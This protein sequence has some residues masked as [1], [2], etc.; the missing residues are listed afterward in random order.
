MI[1]FSEKMTKLLCEYKNLLKKHLPHEQRIIK[2]S[3]LGLKR[4]KMRFNSD[5][6][7]YQKTLSV[8]NDIGKWIESN[9]QSS[10]YSGIEEFHH[11]LKKEIQ[12]YRVEGDKIVHATQTASK[13]MVTAFQFAAFPDNQLTTHIS[14][15]LEEYSVIIVKYGTDEQKNIFANAL[16]LQQKRNSPFFTPLLTHFEYTRDNHVSSG[17]NGKVA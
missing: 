2:L 11:H 4:K 5:I 13:V 6:D 17:N 8:M 14:K 1:T 16:K 3:E 15:Q 12:H 9:S 7:L 10:W